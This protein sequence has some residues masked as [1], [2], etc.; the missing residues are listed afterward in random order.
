MNITPHCR[1]SKRGQATRPPIYAARR[2]AHRRAGCRDDQTNAALNA[3]VRP[4]RPHGYRCRGSCSCRPCQA[5][6]APS[7]RA[8]AAF[9]LRV[10]GELGFRYIAVERA[11]LVEQGK[12]GRA[13]AVRAVVIARASIAAHVYSALFSV[14]SDIGT[15]SSLDF[16][17][18]RISLARPA[19]SASVSR[20]AN[21]VDPRSRPA[22]GLARHRGAQWMGAHDKTPPVSSQY[23]VWSIPPGLRVRA[24]FVSGWGAILETGMAWACLMPGSC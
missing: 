15:P 1:G 10:V 14:L 17:R 7:R 23:N 16:H 6:A 24:G 20:Q 21:R 13:E 22:R 18:S 4:N 11:L 5:G 9:F 8:A 3:R 12:C 19:L 2:R